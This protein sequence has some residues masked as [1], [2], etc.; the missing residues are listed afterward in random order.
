MHGTAAFYAMSTLNIGG[1]LVTVPGRRFDPAALLDAVSTHRA[2]GLCIVGD[3]FARPLVAELEDAD[4][5]RYDLSS[6]RVI[7][8]S[9]VMFS[10][11]TKT[12]LLHRATRAVVVD[13]LGSS[14][15][16]ALASSVT[17]G[18]GGDTARFEVNERTRVLDEHGRDVEWGSGQVGRLATRGRIPLGYLNDP[19]KTASTFIE[20]DG[21]RYVM[22]GD[23]AEVL[24]DGAIRLLGRGS[25]CI[26][27]AGEKVFPEEVEEVLKTHPGV[28]DVVV[29]GVP[30]E[31]LGEA[32]A[33]VVASGQAPQPD[34]SELV[35]HVKARLAGYKA[36]RHV[37]FVEDL[38]RDV[39]GK[40][41][42]VRI[43]ELAAS[44]LGRPTT[45]R[46]QRAARLAGEAGRP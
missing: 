13:S 4:E 39:N 28:A 40:P 23:W 43:K 35:A 37:V 38:G 20:V 25:A 14:E 1:A 7:F 41:P 11:E 19:A 10:S 32:V 3:A 27:T 44:Q 15:S 29:V 9:G 31:R 34:T 36:P 12:A 22:A 33:A 8:S 21:A 42:L 5:D 6:L 2:A 24:A 30:D 46:D 16:G 17:S 26:N 45:D 18:T